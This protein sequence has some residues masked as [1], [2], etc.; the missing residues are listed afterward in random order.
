MF[1][2]KLEKNTNWLHYVT[3]YSYKIVALIKT[4][5]K[6]KICN[7]RKFQ[8]LIKRDTWSEEYFRCPEPGGSNFQG[9]SIRQD[10]RLSLRLQGLL[11]LG[12]RC[13]VAGL[14]LDRSHDLELG[15]RPEVD[16]FIENR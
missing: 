5:L 6:L 3:I 8:N 1:C 15:R 9:A 10:K 11:L 12:V 16:A 14:L 7:L 4:P 13:Q 2:F